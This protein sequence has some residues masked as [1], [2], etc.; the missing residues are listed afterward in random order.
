MKKEKLN[1]MVNNLATSSKGSNLTGKNVFISG[2]TRGFVLEMAK[3]F[4]KLGCAVTVGSRSTENCLHAQQELKTIHNKVQ[5]LQFD[6][7]N[8]EEVASALK[9]SHELFGD[10]DVVIAAQAGNFVAPANQISANGFK[11]IVEID[12]I[13]TFNLFRSSWDFLKKPG[14]SLIAITTPSA[15]KPVTNQAHVCSAKAGVNMLIK[16]LA[17]EWGGS[18]IRVNGISPGPVMDSFGMDKVLA[19]DKAI[20]EKVLSMLPLGRYA[21]SSEISKLGQ[22]LASDD[23]SYIT[24]TILDID[25]GMQLNMHS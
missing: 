7:R 13:G 14:A 15:S 6:A 18:G 22:F 10:F 17:L 5:A 19:T 21:H 1:L 11:T 25:G 20:Q 4:A 3:D 16:C 24:G 2:G 23:S 12:L 9:N 8:Y